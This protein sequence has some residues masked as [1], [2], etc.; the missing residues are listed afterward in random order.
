MNELIKLT[1]LHEK[2]FIR[3]WM[4]EET[5]ELSDGFGWGI[6]YYAAPALGIEDPAESIDI[7][8]STPP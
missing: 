5:Y 4:N 7:H 8:S 6:V 1:Q 3:Q 2:C